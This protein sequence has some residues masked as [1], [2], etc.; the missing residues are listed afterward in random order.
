MSLLAWLLLED[1]A[2]AWPLAIGVVQK[3]RHFAIP[4]LLLLDIYFKIWKKWV[5]IERAILKTKLLLKLA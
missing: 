2:S 3:L 4:L 5:S 1:H